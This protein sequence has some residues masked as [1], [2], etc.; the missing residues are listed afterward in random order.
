MKARV[1]LGLAF[2]ASMLLAFS[3]GH[4]QQSSAERVRAF[5]ALPNW[6][7]LWETETSAAFS[8]GDISGEAELA[9][10]TALWGTPPYNSEWLKKSQAGQGQLAH[11]ATFCSPPGF[12]AVMEN[13]TSAG[14]FQTVVTPEETILLFPDE[15]VRH[16]HTDG[17]DHPKKSDLWPTG[18]GDS[19]GRWE[20][21]TLVVDTVARKAGPIIHFP[22]IA[23]LSERARFTERI[24]RLDKDTLQDRMTID[25]P[26]R[27]EHPWSIAI[28]Y[29]RVTDVDRLI[30]VGCSEN[31]RNPVVDGKFTIAPPSRTG[32][33]QR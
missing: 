10:R 8:V 15:E 31:E 11:A 2:V 20:G 12:P 25:D 22:G 14:M 29:K 7:G 13:P 26:L 4:T 33:P 30:E 18:M 23:D 21:A 5:A 32:F 6:T 24:T 16:I 1:L 28:R 19:V 27:F 17:R 9:K 3:A